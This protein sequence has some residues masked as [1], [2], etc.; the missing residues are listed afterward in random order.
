M[1][2]SAVLV[3]ACQPKPAPTST[4]EPGAGG[5]QKKVAAGGFAEIAA[6][7]KGGQSYRCTF[8]MKEKNQQMTYAIKGQKVAMVIPAQEGSSAG[9]SHMLTDG[10]TL[11][12]WDEMTKKGMM[13]V[14]PETPSAA[15]SALPVGQPSVPNL[16][17]VEDWEELQQQYEVNC[18]PASLNDSE[19]TPPTDV[20]FQ[21]LSKMM[22]AGAGAGAGM[23]PSGV[24]ANLPTAVPARMPI[25]Y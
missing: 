22:P 15:P 18:T 12:I 16:E 14:V 6:A 7:I 21:D 13:M 3:S 11:Y 19:F 23:M 9:V 17:D 20:T 8:T 1:L 5:E 25:Q 4:T 2:V 24:P 10:K